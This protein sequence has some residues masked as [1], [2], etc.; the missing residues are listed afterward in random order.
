VRRLLFGLLLFWRTEAW[1]AE[2]E[3]G[4][5]YFYIRPAES[6]ALDL[7]TAM[8]FGVTAEVFWWDR[9]STHLAASFSQPQAIL[10]R[11]LDL[12]TLGINP[13][14]LTARYHL[15]PQS[16]LSPFIG[17]G[18]ALVMLGN[19]DDFFGDEILAEFENETAFAAEAGLRWRLTPHVRLEAA[20]SRIALRA[21][22]LV[23]KSN[24]PLPSM[25][26]IDPLSASGGV[27]WRF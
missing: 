10:G 13:I 4:G 20:L 26:E 3:V 22:P 24:V 21:V 14:A 23:R 8:G 25:I 6:G 18:G 19:L 5:R 9:V 27:S 7:Q 2:L 15:A 12:G 1:S 11:N 17:A 16:R